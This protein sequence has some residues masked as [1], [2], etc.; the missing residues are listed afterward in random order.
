MARIRICI[1]GSTGSIGQS[2]LDVV[3]CYPDRF[4]VVGLAA[5]SNVPLLAAQVA[6]FR[7]ARVAVVDET[8]ADRVSDECGGVEVWAG[9]EGLERLAGEP[10]DILLCAVVGAAG[11]R[12]LLRAIDAGN[13][14]A[15]AN[16]ESLVMAGRVVME[17]ARARGVDIL[18]VDSEHN[19]VFQCLEGHRI[20][21]V[22]AIYLTAS[23]GPFYGRSR[24][25]LRQVTPADA[26]NHPT[27]SMGAKISIDS[28]TLMNKGLEVME[29]MWLFGLPL[30]KVKVVIH[31]Q[32]VVHGL[33]EFNDG[34]ILAQ[35]GVTDMRFP[36]QFALTWPERVESPMKRLDLSALR[37]L[38]FAPPDFGQFPCLALALQAAERG[39]TAPAI[40]NAANEEA[41]RAFRE[42]R[43]GFLDIERVVSDTLASV[44]S[45]AESSYE[46]VVEA[47]ALA[48]AHA[49]R[50]VVAT[51]EDV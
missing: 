28:A 15:L 41:V 11:L 49:E 17:R 22:H 32:S 39:G 6:E 38:A 7:P 16:K 12:P 30:S 48:R 42:G 25:S 9:E 29:A 3:R 20:E 46:A 47:D 2:A 19:A 43:V 36:I 13:R 21:D 26:T 18:P 44:A 34:S 27:W 5:H 4:E 14:I 31:P 10:V 23:G 8:A 45:G 35:L 24:R 40:L 50:I 33:V 51:G 37:T 1:L